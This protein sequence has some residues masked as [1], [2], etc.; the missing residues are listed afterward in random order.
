MDFFV[1]NDRELVRARR[2]KNEHGVSF[3]SLVH[4][5]PVKSA[6]R[7]GQRIA[8]QL[9]ALNENADLSGR[10]RLRI[11]DRLY[12]LVVLKL[13]EKFLRPHLPAST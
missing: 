6:V 8:I 10:F 4:A 3:R 1:T 11:P 7:R 12:D 2:H 13:G 5:K 9:A